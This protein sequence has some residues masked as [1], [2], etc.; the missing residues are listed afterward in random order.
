MFILL[1]IIMRGH[2]LHF[3]LFLISLFVVTNVTAN[4]KVYLHFDNTSYYLGEMI[5]FSAYVNDI[6]T[7]RPTTLSEILYT[8]ILSPEGD[9][10]DTHV[11]K[12]SKGACF[13]NFTLPL[14]LKSGFFEIRA[15][16]RYML[17]YGEDNYFSRV[18]PI[19]DEVKG[20]MYSYRYMLNRK[21]VV[22][23]VGVSKPLVRQKQTNTISSTSPSLLTVSFDST[24]LKPFSKN[25]LLIHGEP[26]VTFSLSVTDA[27]SSYHSS[28]TNN[29]QSS[30]IDVASYPKSK[31][32]PL[33]SAIVQPEKNLSLSG[34]VVDKRT[35][36]KSRDKVEGMP[37]CLLHYAF[38]SSSYTLHDS[39]NTDNNGYFNIPL[40]DFHGS[41]M[42][43]IFCNDDSKNA[44]VTVDKWFSP[45]VKGYS[46]EEIDLQPKNDKDSFYLY[47]N[48][49]ECIHSAQVFNLAEE[50]EWMVDHNRDCKKPKGLNQFYSTS[51][52]VES[53]F[54]HHNFPVAATRLVYLTDSV[55][56]WIYDGMSRPFEKVKYL[57][58]NS[59]WNTCKAF[60]YDKFKCEDMKR[61]T[62]YTEDNTVFE[63]Y[64]GTSEPCRFP[65][66]IMYL[67]PFDDNE[68]PSAKY[69]FN[70]DDKIRYTSVQG[71]SQIGRFVSPRNKD[72]QPVVTSDYRRTLY[73]SPTVQ[74]DNDGNAVIE[75]YNNSSCSKV[76]ISAEGITFDGR[77]IV[78]R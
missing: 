30:F 16:T 26:N 61:N 75:F 55:A 62:Y 23:T 14:Y 37:P 71:F 54:L 58:V 25:K 65:S 74:T 6:E 24:Q 3:N 36:F 64:L 32:T 33:N 38:E 68:E 31:Q 12:L 8:E 53:V 45:P 50:I 77:A 21:R 17:N 11:Y 9:V 41:S 69:R 15:Y 34:R 60:S 39:I 63:S 66:Y 78:N 7:N 1:Q 56:L 73:W 4:E 40:P 51:D 10:I 72:S 18:I 49:N 76:L 48:D 19:F 59:D 35:R 22:D 57:I 29:I 2:I 46:P 44:A 70:I 67:I 20:G 52:I 28:R 42:A 43:Q 27:A 13:G 47:T 5:W